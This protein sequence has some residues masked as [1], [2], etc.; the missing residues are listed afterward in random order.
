MSKTK[1]S[2][3]SPSV[4]ACASGPSALAFP[5]LDDLLSHPVHRPQTVPSLRKAQGIQEQHHPLSPYPFALRQRR[6]LRRHS[7]RE[8]RIPV[9]QQHDQRTHW[10]IPASGMGISFTL[11]DV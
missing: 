8:S 9:P 4:G 3:R 7:Q 11:L 5:A 1:R 10:P 2:P 6:L